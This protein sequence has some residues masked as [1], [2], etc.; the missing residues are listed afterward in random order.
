M[1]GYASCS[2]AIAVVVQGMSLNTFGHHFQ[3]SPCSDY[4][5]IHSFLPTRND[6]RTYD[7][8]LEDYVAQIQSMMRW[9]N[10]RRTLS[11]RRTFHDGFGGS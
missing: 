9:S 7:K 6:V 5:V 11:F 3:C 10:L 1:S 2:K 4:L 8:A